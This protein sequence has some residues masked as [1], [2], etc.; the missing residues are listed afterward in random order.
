MHDNEKDK[1]AALMGIIYQTA[2]A[3]WKNASEAQRSACRKC[4]SIIPTVSESHPAGEGNFESDWAEALT[5]CAISLVGKK[6]F[7][8]IANKHLRKP[9]PK[10]WSK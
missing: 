9:I 4:G 3:D 7:K 5:K 8:E 10:L 6:P 1:L 2:E